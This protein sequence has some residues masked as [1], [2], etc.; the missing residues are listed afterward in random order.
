MRHMVRGSWSTLRPERKLWALGSLRGLAGRVAGGGRGAGAGAHRVVLSL[1]RRDPAR[2]AVDAAG[3]LRGGAGAAR[4]AAAA[5]LGARYRGGRA[6][7][8]G[9]GSLW[10]GAVRRG[11][12]C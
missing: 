9:E 8:A 12:R 6:G 5:A 11:G 1:R 3:E 7:R 2:P 4:I 10:A